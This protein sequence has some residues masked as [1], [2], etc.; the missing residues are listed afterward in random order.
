MWTQLK[1]KFSKGF[2]IQPPAGFT[3][4]GITIRGEANTMKAENVINKTIM[5]ALSH[6]DGVKSLFYDSI[7]KV[8]R[9]KLDEKE[10]AVLMDYD[11][12]PFD[13]L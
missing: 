6:V 3:T 2:A 4:N 13:V 5:N 7:Q 11:S 12:V 10:F 8:V 1:F 9:F